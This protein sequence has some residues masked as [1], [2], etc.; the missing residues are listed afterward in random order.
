M[1]CLALVIGSHAAAQTAQSEAPIDEVVITATGR[2]GALADTPVSVSAYD[3]ADLRNGGVDTVKALF[4]ISPSLSVVNSFSE[5]FGQFLRIRGVAT[6]GADIGIESAAGITIDG[7]PISRPNLSIGDLQGVERIEFL[8]GPQGTLFG[9]NTTTGVVNVITRQPSFTPQFE[10]AATI[11]NIGAG[12]L[13]L[14]GSGPLSDGELAG[15]LDLLHATSEGYVRHLRTGAYYG[16][17]RRSEIRAQ[18][19][20]NPASSLD[21]RV[22][23]DHF[24]HDGTTSGPVFRVVGPAGAVISVLSGTPLVAIPDAAPTTQIDSDTPRFQRNRS[25]GI[26]AQGNWDAGGGAV[27]AIIAYRDAEFARDYDIDNGP[28]DL[29]HDPRDGENYQTLTFEMRGRKQS[30]PWDHLIG[31]FF[32]REIVTSLDS[33]AVGSDFEL[34]ANTAAMGLIPAVTG[35]P[36]GQNFPAGSG[37]FDRFHQ[38]STKAAI[39]AHEI[40]LLSDATSLTGGLRYTYETKELNADLF[41]DNPGCSRAVLIHGIAL[42]AVPPSLRYLVCVPNLDP[43]FDGAY[44]TE[45]DEG[46]WSGTA[47]ITRRFSESF[48]GYLSYSRGYKAGGYQFDRSGMSATAPSAVQL[49]F[50]AEHADSYEVGVRTRLFGG[51]VQANAIAFYTKFSDHQLN[52]FTGLNRR[53]VNVPD[54]V[55]KGVEFEGSYAAAENFAL[56]A[57][58]TYQEVLFGRSGFPA[59]LTQLQGATAPLAPRWTAVGTARYGRPLFN[60]GLNASAYFDVRWQSGADVGA[61]AVASPNFRQEAYAVA[62]TRLTI[63][64]ETGPWS[65]ELW[66]RNLFDQRAWSVLISTTLQPGSVSGYVIEPRTFGAT[67]R[68][69]W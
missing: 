55:T 58:A 17:L 64:Q 47:A 59:G 65:L 35:L 46:D 69:R 11:G 60:T 15:R 45:D 7:V 39:F 25:S 18:A 12:D 3:G 9:K 1:T 8:R 63:A 16:G 34:Y 20:W 43:R 42:A 27:T 13:R 53:T 62:G 26:S 2:V 36:L 61:S 49:R 50:A 52:Y 14:M 66:A 32:S 33:Y 23:A 24:D 51:A 44:A 6:S 4:A 54:L 30:G 41:A 38:R 22:I 5:S 68:A 28:A 29:I 10:A 31:A 19:L 57:A 67:L 21:L 40:V 56:S 48:T 37:V